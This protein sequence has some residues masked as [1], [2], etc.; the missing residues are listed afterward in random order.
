[1][2]LY[3]AR[4]FWYLRRINQDRAEQ[5]FRRIADAGLLGHLFDHLPDVYLFVKNERHEFMMVNRAL[6]TLHGCSSA[7]SMIGKTDWDFSPPVLAQQYVDEDLRIMRSGRP[8]ADQIWLVSGADGVPRW[9]LSTKMPLRDREG[10]IIGIAGVMRPYE[11]VGDSPGEY[12]RLTAAI[13]HVLQHFGM[14]IEV[15]DLARL[16]HLSISQFQREFQRLFAMTP[17]AYI[18]QVR[19]LAARHRLEISHASLGEIAQAC[20]F[21]DQ[22]YFSKRFKMALGVRPLE[23]RRQRAGGRVV[24]HG[25]RV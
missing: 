19:I 22:S 13:D 23:Y 16:A 4:L 21:Y 1:M 9:Y 10:A 2:R 24:H 5:F 3:S 14:P 25:T 8:L 17:R 15:R 18:M 12:R 7:S 11:R 20:G 6:W